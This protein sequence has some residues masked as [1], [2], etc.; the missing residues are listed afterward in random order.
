M[1]HRGPYEYDKFTLNILQISNAVAL[2]ELQE[3]TVNSN[4]KNNLLEIQK[5]I[6]EVY[7]SLVGNDDVI[8]LTEKIYI[9]S[10]LLKGEI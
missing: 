7:T 6:N 3:L 8:G 4:N 1:R 9:N 2:S 5:K 10:F